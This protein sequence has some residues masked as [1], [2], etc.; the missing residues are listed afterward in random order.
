MRNK[1]IAGAAALAVAAA[2]L[3]YVVSM[4]PF[5]SGQG[6]LALLDPA[7]I[8]VLRTPGGLL[9]VS[10]LV[11]IEEFAWQTTYTCPLVDCGK[12]LGS[13]VSRIRVPAHFVYRVPLAESW[14]MKLEGG[15]YVLTVPR[16]QLLKPVAIDSTR[17]EIQTSRGWLAP[18]GPANV[19]AMLRSFGPVLEVRGEDPAYQKAQ[20]AEA[21]KTIRE[22]AAKWM[23]EQSIDVKR[24][25]RVRFGGAAPA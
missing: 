4:Q 8:V 15:S 10:H 20:Q 18:D 23:R 22:F 19:Q 13:T 1:R 11:K 7:R 5:G 25:I 3:V 17:L 12:W 16:P 6:P 21:E 14:T 24:P 2:G 9:E